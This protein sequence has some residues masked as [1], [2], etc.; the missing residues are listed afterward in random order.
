MTCYLD[1]VSASIP[2]NTSLAVNL[3]TP[4]YGKTIYICKTNPL[5]LLIIPCLN[6]CWSNNNPPNLK[7]NKM[8]TTMVIITKKRK[9]KG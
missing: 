9:K 3:S 8:L 7:N 4:I 1:L 2:P 5:L 6:V